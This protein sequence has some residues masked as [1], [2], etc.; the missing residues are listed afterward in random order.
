MILNRYNPLLH[1]IA[2][3][4]ACATFPLIFLGGLVTSHGAGMSVPDW[5]TS[6]GYNMWLLPIGQWWHQGGIFYE[7][8]HRLVASGVG[9]MAIILAAAAWWMEPRAWVRRLAYLVLGFVIFQ[10][11][12]GGMR[13]LFVNLDLAI[14]HG[15]TAQ[16]FFCTAVL[17]AIVTSRWW[18][19]APNLA[20][21]ESYA[22]GHKLIRM[23]VEAVAMVFIQ[24]VIGAIMRHE[25]AG[26][27]MYGRFLPPV[28]QAGLD[29]FNA[30]RAYD[31]QLDPVSM[32]QVW[33][34]F[35]HQIGA[36]LVT[37]AVLHLIVQV[38]RK[39][40][41]HNMLAGPA[42]ALAVL[43][44]TQITLGVATVYFKKPADVASAHVATGALIL[45]TCFTIAVRSM[46]L[47]SRQFRER[48]ELVRVE[49]RSIG[50]EGFLVS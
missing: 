17:A 50:A 30:H 44:L 33:L 2:L 15:I 38:L 41:S 16:L 5:P 23:G 21:S 13:V 29:A 19:L 27:A 31:L 7:H 1:R 4:T 22:D 42:V 48:S 9:F 20:W 14:A 28:T 12:L 8:S 35:A 36:V 46:R 49:V 24:L 32:A 37:G 11:V 34:Q 47:Y 18:N 39:H 10:G 3:L 43:L 45:V 40:R 26:L 25:Q 6:F